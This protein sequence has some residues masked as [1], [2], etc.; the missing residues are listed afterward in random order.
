MTLIR[1]TRQ[2]QEQGDRD[3]QEHAHLEFVMAGVTDVATSLQQ[4]MGSSDPFRH[5]LAGNG[6]ALELP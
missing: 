6:L 3:W 2:Q 4:D 1:D 5:F